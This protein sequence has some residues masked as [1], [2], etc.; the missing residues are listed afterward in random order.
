MNVRI[1]E[2]ISYRTGDR[3]AKHVLPPARRI[4]IDDAIDR[5]PGRAARRDHDLRVTSG[6]DDN[7]A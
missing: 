7:Q 4:V 5:V 1:L 6:A 3:H 2:S